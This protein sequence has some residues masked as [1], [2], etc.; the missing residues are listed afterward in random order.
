MDKRTNRTTVRKTENKTNVRKNLSINTTSLNKPLTKHSVTN[1][2][3]HPIPS[4]HPAPNLQTHRAPQSPDAARTTPNNTPETAPIYH[5]KRRLTHDNAYTPTPTPADAK[6]TRK[7]PSQP[8][9]APQTPDNSYPLPLTTIT[10]NVP[11]IAPQ[12]RIRRLPS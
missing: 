1:T 5:A 11:H 6:P 9:T 2:I 8:A 7:Y 3:P 4:H 12:R 10:Q